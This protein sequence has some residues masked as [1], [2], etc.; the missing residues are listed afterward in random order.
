MR[1]TPYILEVSMQQTK[2]SLLVLKTTERQEMFCQLTGSTCV[3][4]R[5][6]IQSE[7]TKAETRLSACEAEWL[8]LDRS[9]KRR[10]WVDGSRHLV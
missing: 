1:E 10:V 2:I 4:T 5:I 7:S 3:S 6:R 8:S 9:E